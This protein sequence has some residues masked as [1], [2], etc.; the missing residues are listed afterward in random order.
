MIQAGTFLPS[1]LRALEDGKLQKKA[2][3]ALARLKACNLC[4]RRCGVDR[5]SGE[6]GF[7][8]TGRQ[9]V[10]SSY[11]PHFGEEDPLV[12]SRGSGTVFFTHCNLQCCFCQNY[13]ISQLGDG[14]PA[15]AE[16]RP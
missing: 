16:I 9:A 12:G 5:L 8:R 4:P 1:Y 3:Q 14:L 7:C 6:R 15:D 11:G 13:E 2:E 10:V